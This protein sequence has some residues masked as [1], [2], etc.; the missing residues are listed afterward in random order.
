VSTL[1]ESLT[2]IA[3]AWARR[4]AFQVSRDPQQC[5]SDPITKPRRQP[6]AYV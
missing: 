2:R 6:W 4:N 5:R 3:E 1:K